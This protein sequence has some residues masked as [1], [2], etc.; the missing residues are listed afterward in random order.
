MCAGRIS[1]D[2][3]HSNRSSLELQHSNA[4]TLGKDRMELRDYLN[5][6]RARKG[7][8]I[9]SALIV[10]L[11]ALSVSMIQPKTYAGRG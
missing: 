11:T 5:V 9:A 7:I 4:Y 8:I 1:Y 2:G 6:I 3:K 10:A